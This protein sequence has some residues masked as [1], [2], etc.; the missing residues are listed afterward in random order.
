MDKKML[1]LEIIKSHLSLV[2]TTFIISFTGLITTIAVKF[3]IANPYYS[4]HLYYKPLNSI[5]LLLAVL[6]ISQLILHVYYT[7]K[8]KKLAK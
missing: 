7:E 5:A 8:M 6:V 4:D 1:E 3:T 2:N